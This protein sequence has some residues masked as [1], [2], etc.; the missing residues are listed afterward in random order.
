MLDYHEHLEKDVAVKKW[1]DEQ[2]K[3]FAA[4]TETLFD[5]G[6]IGNLDGKMRWLF[7]YKDHDLAWNPDMDLIVHWGLHK[8]LR[9]YR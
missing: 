6:V 1:I 3:T 5:F 9:I 8:K 7:K 2:G 4:V